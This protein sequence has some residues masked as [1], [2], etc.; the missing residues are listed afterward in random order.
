MP[1]LM[2]ILVR[3][4]LVDFSETFDRN[5]ENFGVKIIFLKK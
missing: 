1:D 5:K 3:S 2:V 4:I